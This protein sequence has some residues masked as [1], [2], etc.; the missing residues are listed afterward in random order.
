MQSVTGMTAGA[1]VVEVLIV[2]LC[3]VLGAAIEKKMWMILRQHGEQKR[4]SWEV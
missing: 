3:P 4:A 2:V 1:G